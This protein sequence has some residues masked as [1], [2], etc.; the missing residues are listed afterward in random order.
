MDSAA[1]S[2]CSNVA[3]DRGRARTGR[4]RS[5]RL[6]PSAAFAYG[7]QSAI[8]R[9]ALLALALSATLPAGGQLIAERYSPT[10]SLGLATNGAV[11]FSL[12]SYAKT[13][14]LPSPWSQSPIPPPSLAPEIR[15]RL[16]ARRTQTVAQ[17]V[18][19]TNRTFAGF[20]PES[21][22][23]LAWTNLLA[24]TNGRSPVIWSQ[25][26]HPLG[27]PLRPPV[28]KWNP[29][30]L[31]W[32]MRGLTALSP[33]WQ[34]EASPGQ[35]PVT[36]LTR[37]HG[38]TRGHGMGQEG[39]RQ[40]Y[41][42][43]RVWFLST[44]NTIVQVKVTRELVRTTS[45]SN[46]D[47]TLLLFDRDLPDSIQPMRVCSLQELTARFTFFDRIPCPLLMTEQDG[48]V[49]AGIPGFAFDVLKGGD[50]GSP[51]MLLLPGELVFYNGRTTSPPGSEMQEDM[52]ELCRRE[53][54]NPEKY[55]LQWVSLT[56]Y[57][58]YRTRD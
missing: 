12:T 39:F 1:S 27:W 20:Q 15:E 10:N 25:R 48:N 18:F 35:M 53:G 28:V 57:P 26:T 24:H 40:I 58:E 3:D 36:A 6:N 16:L 34:G 55:R 30:G 54:L 43:S 32:G 50:S 49:S 5:L 38:Y 8:L 44:D 14:I 29:S 4:F 31:M 23:N 33:C 19:F 13:N 11:I 52:D 46:Q 22:I 37:R 56:A 45:S 41:A 47:Y 21:L 2:P 17:V 42:G 9:V 7:V 51:N